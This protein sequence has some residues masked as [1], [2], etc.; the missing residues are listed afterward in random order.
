[1]AIHPQTQTHSRIQ[2]VGGQNIATSIRTF[3]THR[4]LATHTGSLPTRTVPSTV[5]E[6][7]GISQPELSIVKTKFARSGYVIGIGTSTLLP[8]SLL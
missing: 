3:N 8:A 1:M 7:V 4:S 2:K 5:I 6:T